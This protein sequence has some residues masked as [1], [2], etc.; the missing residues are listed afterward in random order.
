MKDAAPQFRGGIFF[1]S[2]CYAGNMPY[3]VFR[4]HLFLSYSQ[5]LF[6]LLHNN[7]K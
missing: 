5:L 7:I 4:N 3:A 1:T 2:I 6:L